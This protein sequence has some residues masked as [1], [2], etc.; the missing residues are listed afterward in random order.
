MKRTTLFVFST[1]MLVIAFSACQTQTE[2]TFE[3]EWAGEDLQEIISN[4]ESQHGGFDITMMQTSYRYNEIY[5]AGQDE[6][7]GYAD[8]QLHE[9]LEGLED[10]FVR[11]PEREASAAQFVDQAAPR[12]L[13]AIEAGD[14]AAFQESFIRFASSCNT[15]HAMEDMPFIQVIIPEIRTSLVKL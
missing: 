7:W 8:Y 10:G 15:C 2:Q 4:L 1:M 5:W 9:M 12:L 13:Q 6:N 14:K 11:R 3:T